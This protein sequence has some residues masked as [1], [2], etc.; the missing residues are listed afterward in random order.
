MTN[1]SGCVEMPRIVPLCATS[2]PAGRQRDGHPRSSQT[3]GHLCKAVLTFYTLGIS[4]EFICTVSAASL[5]YVTSS[6]WDPK[7]SNA[8]MN[9]LN[10]LYH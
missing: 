3:E 5:N 4:S 8:T 9:P 2:A 10:E 7:C 6:C 1:L